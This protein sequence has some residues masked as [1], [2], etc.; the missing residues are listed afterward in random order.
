SRGLLTL[1]QPRQSQQKKPSRSPPTLLGS[2]LLVGVAPVAADPVPA[3]LVGQLQAVV[4]AL[5]VQPARTSGG[6]RSLRIR[7]GRVVHAPTLST[8]YVRLFP[9]KDRG[10][11]TRRWRAG[12]ARRCSGPPQSGARP[13]LSRREMAVRP[14]AHVAPMTS[15]TRPL[16]GDPTLRTPTAALHPRAPR[17]SG[18]DATVS[19]RRALSDPSRTRSPPAGPPRLPRSRALQRHPETGRRAAAPSAS[20]TSSAAATPPRRTAPP[21]KRPAPPSA[22]APLLPRPRTDA[23]PRRARVDKGGARTAP[24]RPAGASPTWHPGTRSSPTDASG[25]PFAA[26]RARLPSPHSSSRLR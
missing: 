10:G 24:G 22:P 21:R 12:L 19:P 11:A 26:R 23:P 13:P 4:V 17:L 5:A 8:D 2:L 25:C 20:R 3:K 16:P 15:P 7:A 18:S 9:T 6:A 14:L 1:S